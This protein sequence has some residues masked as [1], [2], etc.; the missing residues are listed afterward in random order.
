MLRGFVYP[1]IKGILTAISKKAAN[2]GIRPNHLT[3]GGLGLSFVAAA[4]YASGHFFFG[5]IFTLAAGAC[6]MLD[7]ALAR[8]EAKTSSFGA[9]LDS[10]I[11]R[12]SD[13]ILFSGI[14]IHYGIR[15]RVGIQV[16]I[17]VVM[18]GSLLTSYTKARSESLVTPCDVG[19]IERPERIIIL[20][21]GSLFGLLIPALWFL[22]I[23]S[24]LTVIQRILHVRRQMRK[25]P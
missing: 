6:D 13:F 20:A 23:A 5:G 19:M 10:T 7:G 15:G 4:I 24:H 11:D 2:L 9:F 21:A 16:L 17:L 3:F 1:R 8:L 12:Y 18:L 22:A 14:L 25:K